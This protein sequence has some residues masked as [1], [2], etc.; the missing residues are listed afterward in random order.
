MFSQIVSKSSA[1]AETVRLTNNGR[2]NSSTETD[3][4]TDSQMR[5]YSLQ[6]LA[7]RLT[8]REGQ[9]DIPTTETVRQTNSERRTYQLNKLPARLTYPLKKLPV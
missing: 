3:H 8:V 7:A 9:P 2:S 5:T 6:K 4:R 1:T